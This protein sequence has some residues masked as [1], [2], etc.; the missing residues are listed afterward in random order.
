MVVVGAHR[1]TVEGAA[2]ADDNTSGVAA[3]L[4]MAEVLQRTPLPATVRFVLFGAEEF[5]LLGSDYYVHHIGSDQTIG[6]VNVDMEGA[7]ERL[8]LAVYRGPD[9]LVMVASHLAEQLGIKTQVA[10]SDGSDHVS[11]ERAGGPVVFLLRPDYSYL[12]T[13]KDT[14]DR[15]DPKLLEVSAR[16]ATA[17]VVTVA[18]GGH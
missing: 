12:H 4:E 3:V 1:D 10:P 15:I 17:I 7:G 5:G 2:G 11:F 16:L 8:Q 9:T 6:M 13:P 18:G 14:V